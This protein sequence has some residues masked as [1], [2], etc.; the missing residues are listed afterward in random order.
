M[1]SK[2]DPY[3]NKLDPKTEAA[4]AQ[5]PRSGGT[6]AQASQQ[7]ST[8]DRVSLSS[9]ARLHTTAHTEAS[10]APE[11]RQA[12]VDSI[13]ERIAAG[14]YS[15]DAKQIARKLVESEADFVS[16]LKE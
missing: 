16:A 2:L 12:K 9:A 5:K 14:T 10:N 15:P 11:V 3:R 4:A 8:G 13:K 1:L 6:E 7:A